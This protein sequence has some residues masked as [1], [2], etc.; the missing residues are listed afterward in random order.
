M[1]WWP[2]FLVA[3]AALKTKQKLEKASSFETPRYRLINQGISE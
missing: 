2:L 1:E 3:A